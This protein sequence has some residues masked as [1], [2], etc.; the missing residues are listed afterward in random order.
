[1]TT[2][3]IIAWAQE[4]CPEPVSPYYRPFE[5]AK[6][7]YDRIEDQHGDAAE[8][9]EFAKKIMYMEMAIELAK[10]GWTIEKLEDTRWPTKKSVNLSSL[11]EDDM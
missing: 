1:M 10:I 7:I 8:H 4:N 11:L 2:A 9:D 6:R 5:E 3:E